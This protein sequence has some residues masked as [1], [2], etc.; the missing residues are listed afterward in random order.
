MIEHSQLRSGGAHC[1]VALGGA[2]EGGV[3]SSEHRSNNPHLAGGE[4]TRKGH[5]PRNRR[6]SFE[7]GLKAER[8]KTHSPN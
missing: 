8:S 7:M 4:Q 3:D 1:N 6:I 5:I 2:G